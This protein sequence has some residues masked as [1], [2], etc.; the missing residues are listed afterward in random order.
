[1]SD[2]F[3]QSPLFLSPQRVLLAYTAGSAASSSDMLSI[4]REAQEANEVGGG[5]N[6]TVF[7]INYKIQGRVTAVAVKV[8]KPRTDML[9]R[10]CR[11]SEEV[12]ILRT[13]DH[14]NIVKFIDVAIDM[15]CKIA[16]I[17]EFVD[18]QNLQQEIERR[19]PANQFPQEI[20]DAVAE[21]IIHALAFCEARN[22]S[23]GDV[24]PSNILMDRS[25]TDPPLVKLCDFSEANLGTGTPSYMSPECFANHRDGQTN[26]NIDLFKAD[27]FSAGLT[28]LAL[29]QLHEID[30]INNAVTKLE[31][32]LSNMGRTGFTALLRNMMEW[33][34]G[35]RASFHQL[36]VYLSDHTVQ[37]FD[38]FH[39]EQVFGVPRK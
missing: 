12:K 36:S 9:S 21:Q 11:I 37:F 34:Q 26:V 39:V 17:T 19:L 7:K 33:E 2:H 35:N 1:M 4:F 8:M 24:K 31:Q 28:L 38:E 3:A 32:V 10:V 16:L 27:V 5:S 14:L 29:H 22:I 6:G 20:V 30:G 15:N 18:G 23:H 25:Q 13:L